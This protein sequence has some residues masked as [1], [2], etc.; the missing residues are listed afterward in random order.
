MKPSAFKEYSGLLHRILFM[1]NMQRR[2]FVRTREEALRQL[3]TSMTNTQRAWCLDQAADK[4]FQITKD[5][6]PTRSNN[7]LDTPDDKTTASFAAE[8]QANGSLNRVNYVV[9]QLNALCVLWPTTEDDDRAALTTG[10][11]CAYVQ[12]RLDRLWVVQLKNMGDPVKGELVRWFWDQVSAEMVI[13]HGSLAQS[14]LAD[15]GDA[16]N[17]NGGFAAVVLTL[18]PHNVVERVSMRLDQDGK[19]ADP[20]SPHTVVVNGIVGCARCGHTHDG[21][22]FKELRMKMRNMT[23]WAPCPTNGDP[24]MMQ[25]VDEH[26]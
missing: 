6:T 25:I 3:W 19:I 26:Q 8:M 23:H 20:A 18:Q 17:P 1:R 7:V 15:Y 4:G 10:K 11:L 22:V 13:K 21:V 5:G 9:R 24:I 12:S 2:L 14:F 16:V